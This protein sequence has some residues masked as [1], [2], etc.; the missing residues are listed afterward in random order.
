[1]GQGGTGVNIGLST[2]GFDRPCI[3]YSAA[4]I[5]AYYLLLLS[6]LLVVVLLFYGMLGGEGAAC[7]WERSV[8]LGIGRWERNTA[9]GGLGW[10]L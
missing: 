8:W 2:I 5:F 6:V 3:A 7:F 1:M 4:Y 9:S 10:W